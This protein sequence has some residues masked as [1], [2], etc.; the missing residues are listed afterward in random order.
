MVA[1][2]K[3][4][5]PLKPE[6]L[7]IR[8]R[9]REVMR[10]SRGVRKDRYQKYDKYHYTGH[11]DVTDAL[12]DAFVEFGIDQEIILGE[13]GRRE[14]KSYFVH[15]QIEWINVDNPEDK[16][17]VKSYGE[18][19]ATRDR[20]QKG[21][22]LQFGKAISYAVKVAQLK[23]FMLVGGGI[24]D[25]EA[26]QPAPRNGGGDEREPQSPAVEAVADDQVSVLVQQ[27]KACKTRKDLD[28]VRDAIMPLLKKRRLTQEQEDKLA[29]ADSAAAA[30]VEPS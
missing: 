4:P 26:E 5:Q 2:V 14:D 13:H 1:D 9:K 30:E 3:S 29:A 19:M 10:A 25:N 17:V 8:Q 16:I 28:E 22:D 27:Y 20:G 15:I 23:N 11:D 18:A 7:N 12:H 21:D 24:A 6:L